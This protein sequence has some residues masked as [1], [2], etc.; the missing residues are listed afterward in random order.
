[1]RRLTAASFAF[2]EVCLMFA[3]QNKVLKEIV[4]WIMVIVIAVLAAFV[5]RKFLF[6]MV[7]VDGHSMDYT[8]ADGDRLCVVKLNYKPDNG[9]IIVFDPYGDPSRPYIKR[10]IARSGQTV[11]VD[12]DG[13]VFVDGKALEEDYTGSVSNHGISFAADAAG[14]PV[15][16][17]E[18]EN[19]SQWITPTKDNPYKVPDG[20]IF[21]MGDNRANSRDSRDIGP[22][23]EKD[24]VG[25]A[26]FRVYPFKTF[27]LLK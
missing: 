11:F 18:P 15:R 3:I 27:G 20:Y 26:V 6:T 25:E 16:S 10:V 7:M 21:V 24:V 1:M 17:D 9:D 5:I 13:T 14:K 22:V 2:L 23:N 19:I 12:A 4:D 8:L